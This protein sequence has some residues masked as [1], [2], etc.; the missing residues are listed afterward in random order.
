MGR[1]IGKGGVAA[2]CFRMC[3]AP[4]H[5]PDEV[6]RLMANKVLFLSNGHGEDTVGACMARVLR[7]RTSALPE[8][9]EIDAMPIVGLGTPYA[10]AGIKVVGPRREMPS[11]GFIYLSRKNLRNDL[12]AGLLGLIREQIRFL[13]GVKN[14]YD[15]IIGVGDKVILAVNA[16]ILK[17]DLYFMAIANSSYYTAS[18]SASPFSGWQHRVMQRYARSVYTRDRAT[19]EALWRHGVKQALYFGNPMMDT[20]AVTDEGDLTGGRRCIGLLPGSRQDAY[21]NFSHLLEIA[22]ALEQKGAEKFR[23]LTAL[24]PSLERGEFER[25]LAAASAPVDLVL[26]NRFGDVLNQSEL[27]LGL[28]GTGNEQAAGMGKPVVTFFGVGRQMT[29]RFV[30]GQKKL[31]GGALLVV[32]A[33]P[34]RAAEE[35]DRLLHDGESMAAMSAAGRE[36]MSGCGSTEAMMA[37][38]LQKW[39][40]TRGNLQ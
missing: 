31:L 34:L 5:N 18:G 40:T 17:E 24:A 39:Q 9:V 14:E 35:I 27:I 13:H 12:G 22:T 29:E 19:C 1:K 4:Q 23:F 36:R 11:G 25:L 10:K 2:R 28:S 8:T 21:G 38:I 15:C 3:Q 33:E 30:R 20:F 26:T 37:D 16:L 7:E 6:E 32:P